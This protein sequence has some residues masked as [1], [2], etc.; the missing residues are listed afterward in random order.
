MALTEI[1]L[2]WQA[3]I[4]DRFSVLVKR[5]PGQ[6]TYTH[7]KLVSGCNFDLDSIRLLQQVR[8]G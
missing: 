5:D 8:V 4:T 2:S 6:Q 1:V 7:Y 3:G